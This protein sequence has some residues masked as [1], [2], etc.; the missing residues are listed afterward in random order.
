MMKK[1]LTI[2]IVVMLGLAILIFVSF[3]MNKIR[4]AQSNNYVLVKF[5]SADGLKVNDEV[6][7]RGVKCGM[8]DAIILTN[9]F[10]LVRLWLDKKI[11]VKDKSFV[12][13]QDFGILGGTK[14]IFLQPEGENLY[15]YP[16][17][18]L[19]GEKYDFNIAQIGIILQDIKKIVE[20]AVPEKGKID[21]ITDTLYSA[22]NKINLM[23][24]KNDVDVRRAVND[25]AYASNKVKMVIDSLYPAI[26]S[27]KKEVD[28]FS[29]GSGSVKRILR[30]D[31]VYLRLNKSLLQLN[32][33]LDE[34]KKNKLI[35]GCL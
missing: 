20:N 30:E 5:D 12:A 26:N 21:A 33:L 16:S 31:T 27:I 35:K 15:S 13:L 2:G 4:I 18:T 3:Y 25:I 34:M 32:E 22:L 1:S 14:Y 11:R 24:V 29:E 8:V 23:V 10:V 6:R 7:F 17:D 28:I 19:V 9:D